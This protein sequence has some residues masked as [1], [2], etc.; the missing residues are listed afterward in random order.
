[1]ASSLVI[2]PTGG[3]GNRL[4]VLLTYLELARRQQQTLQVHW[5]PA[6]ECAGHFLDV[7]CPISD[8]RF[9]SQRPTVFDY[10]GCYCCPQIGPLT[11]PIC[12][13]LVLR[14]APAARV[15]ELA[16][17][18]YDAV[19]VRRTDHVA[20]ATKVKKFIPLERFEQFIAAA[21]RPVYLAC[22]N[23]KTQQQL[24]RRYGRK[25]FVHASIGASR[26]LRQTSLTHAVIDLWMCAGSVQFFGTEYSSFTDLIW[27]L[28]ETLPA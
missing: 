23:R 11:A 3:L 22:D 10:R 28:R 19:H 12:A 21:A 13:P 27:T 15:A 20:L 16:E 6:P 18:P 8:V 26:Q 1:M 24:C 14:P 4:R 7:F 25:L 2:V 9:L 17:A 5:K